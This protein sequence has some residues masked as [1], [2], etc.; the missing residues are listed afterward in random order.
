MSGPVSGT[1][2]HLISTITLKV[3]DDFM[4]FCRCG[5]KGVTFFVVGSAS[6]VLRAALPHCA[7]LKELSFKYTTGAGTGFRLANQ[8]ISP[9]GLCGW[10]RGK[11][12]VPAKPITIFL[13]T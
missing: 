4:L 5:P 11:Y 9:P 1:V 13:G 10:A 3:R 2:L 12:M 6:L 7:I 8:G